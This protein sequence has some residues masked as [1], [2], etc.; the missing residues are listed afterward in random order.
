M[1]S[2][3]G[4]KAEIGVFAFLAGFAARLAGLR[5]RRQLNFFYQVFIK[6]TRYAGMM[7]MAF[8]IGR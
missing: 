2:L 8:G 6:N 4:R 1:F 5:F 7:S 3:L